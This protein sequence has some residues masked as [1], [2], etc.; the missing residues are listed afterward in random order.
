MGS[1]PKMF[2]PKYLKSTE[3]FW[4]QAEQNMLG[5]EEL[6]FD[7]KK[8][9]LTPWI[10]DLMGTRDLKKIFFYDLNLVI[11]Y[12]RIIIPPNGLDLIISFSK[13]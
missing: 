6:S 10:K 13:S 1:V 11:S 7:I 9:V 2:F 3:K 8:K 4:K 12:R 5:I